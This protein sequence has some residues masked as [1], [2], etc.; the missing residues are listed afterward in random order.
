MTRF[1]I[2]F[3]ELKQLYGIC[4][5][6]GELFRL[7][8]VDIF[9][10]TPP[11]KTVFDDIENQRRRLE[12]A[13]EKFEDKKEEIKER[14]TERGRAKAQRKLRKISPFLYD[15][16]VN[17][18][19]IKVIFDPVEYIVFRGLTDEN[20]TSLELVDHPS[21]TKEREIVQCSIQQAIAA[22]NIEWQTF[23][24]NDSGKIV[25]EK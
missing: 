11:P 14:A 13:R 12:D 1:L 20:C 23:R 25:Q 19:D 7:S 21:E 17:A 16:A 8:D 2:W 5:C 9:T 4:P 10:K 15:R 22:G 18:N 3:E 6:C 24:I